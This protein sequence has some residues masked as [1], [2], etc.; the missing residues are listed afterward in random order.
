METETHGATAVVNEQVEHWQHGINESGH[1]RIRQLPVEGPS[2]SPIKTLVEVSD[3][4]LV[5][6]DYLTVDLVGGKY[7]YRRNDVSLA[8]GQRTSPDLS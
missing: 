5:T 1:E 4:R 8:R 7:R 6:I 2:P 3:L